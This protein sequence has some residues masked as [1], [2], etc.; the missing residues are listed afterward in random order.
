MKKF[1]AMLTV[2]GILGASGV[3]FAATAKTPAEIASIVTGKTVEDITKE[4]AAGKTYGTIANEAGK[5][6]EFKV[7]IIEQKKEI[8]D[9]RVKD[10]EITQEQADEIYNA[11]KNNQ[12]TCDGTGNAGL[13]RKYGVGFG[14][15]CGLGFSR[16]QGMHNNRR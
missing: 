6:E 7:Q 11:I 9:Q 5:L 12:L 4:R 8:L 14:Q 15:G 16:R 3:V 1:I 10:G 2:I 13:G